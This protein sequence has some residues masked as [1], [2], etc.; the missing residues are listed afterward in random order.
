[1]VLSLLAVAPPAL[2]AKSAALGDKTG[3]HRGVIDA[4]RDPRGIGVRSVGT[5]S[6]VFGARFK[7]SERWTVNFYKLLTPLEL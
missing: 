7:V 5:E 1:M 6:V 2:H 4:R 3:D